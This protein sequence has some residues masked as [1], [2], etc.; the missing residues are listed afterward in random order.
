MDQ[1]ERSRVADAAAK[2]ISDLSSTAFV[3]SREYQLDMALR[4]VHVETICFAWVD[5]AN[6]PYITRNLHHLIEQR[7]HLSKL[8]EKAE[9]QVFKFQLAE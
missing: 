1:K 7:D 2:A 5:P 8:I 3:D 9:A 4:A 6:R